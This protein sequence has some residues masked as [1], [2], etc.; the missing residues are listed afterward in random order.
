MTR[1]LYN[2]QLARSEMRFAAHPQRHKGL[3]WTAIQSKLLAQPEKIQSLMAMEE[4]GGEP[5]VIA[6]DKLTGCYLFVDCSIE[7]P[8][9]RRSVCYD[10]EALA[11]RKNNK[12]LNSAIQMA[13]EMGITLLTEQEY[14]TLQR[15]LPVDTKT[16]SWLLTPPEIRSLGGALFG[17][18][19]YGRT[20][21]YHNGAE[22]YYA[23]RGFRG[24]I[25]I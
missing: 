18:F 4:T 16:S 17:D 23:S 21:T 9:G 3:V 2:S 5:D 10:S 22:S 7:S 1:D 8:K 25:L 19:R 12:P 20:F 6:Y 11:S 14:S 24:K 15:I 13:Q